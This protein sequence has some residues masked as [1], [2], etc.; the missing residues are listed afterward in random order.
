[1][2]SGQLANNDAW[3][4]EYGEGV[5]KSGFAPIFNSDGEIS[6]LLGI[7]YPVPELEQYEE[8]WNY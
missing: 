1:M 6:F 8:P 4:D 7:D 5:Q 2:Y 3:M